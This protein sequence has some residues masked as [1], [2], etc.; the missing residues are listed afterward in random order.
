MQ[1]K[2]LT[3]NIRQGG[4]L[5]RLEGIV[6]RLVNHSPDLI[7]LTEF[8]EGTKGEKIKGSLREAG[9]AYQFSSNPAEKQNGL[10]IAS[11]HPLE[12]LPSTY[13]GTEAVERWME[14]YLPKF[15]LHILGLHIPVEG[16]SLHD[17]KAF[18]NEVKRFADEQKESRVVIMG[19]FNTGL[20]VDT[21]GAMFHCMEDM[22][23]L[24]DVG[25]IDS[26]RYTHGSFTQYSWYSNKGN[27]FRIDHIFLS[28]VLKPYLAEA[29]FSHGERIQK[30][31]DHSL[32]VAELLL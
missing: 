31:S 28:P 20:H 27:G 5:H 29:Y 18:W 25:W 2:L 7:V 21:E 10:L 17:K 26:W 23:Y 32:L 8:W 19:D 3:W 1:M 11:Y 22:Q 6:H 16:S 14:V 12:L 24:L 9:Y 13:G 4:A 30:L 15:D